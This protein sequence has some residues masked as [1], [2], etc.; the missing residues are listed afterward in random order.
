MRRFLIICALL[1]TASASRANEK[2]DIGR[3]WKFFTHEAAR[4]DVAPTVNL[5]H[6]WNADALAGYADYFRGMGNYLKTI[7][8]PASWSG[9]KIYL[10]FQGA[11]MF[12]DVFVNGA[13]AGEHRGGY[14]PFTIDITRFV[15]PG[16]EN[17][18]LVGVSNAVRYDMLP[19]AG[20]NNFYGG[21]IRGAEVIAVPMGGISPNS[22][23]HI[24]Q[25]SVTQDKVEGE[26]LVDIVAERDRNLTVQVAFMSNAMDTVARFAARVKTGTDGTATAKIPFTIVNPTLWNGTISPYL[27][28]VGV[29][30]MDGSYL[31]DS[32]L[33]ET[34][35]RTIAY[36]SAGGLIVN[37]MPYKVNGVKVHQDRPIVGPAI[38]E[39]DAEEDVAM[40]MD[41]GANA[42][43]VVGAPH[44]PY[45]YT[46]CDR[47]GILV[48]SDMPL[49]GGTTVTDK[50]FVNSKP[51]ADAGKAQVMEIMKWQHNHPSVAMWG[52]FSDL[53][54]RGDNP[55]PYVKELNSM[56]KKED[57]SRLT[58]ASSNQDGDIN[59][60][61]DLI[62]WNQ[63]LGWKEGSPEDISVWLTQL[64]NNWRNTPSGISYA[65]GGSATQQED[66]PKQP[67]Y[68]SNWHPEDWQTHLHEVYS[69]A[70]DNT[71]MWGTFVDLFEY[72]SAEYTG[73]AGNG[74]NDTGLVTFDRRTK[75][76]AFYLYKANWNH[77]DPFIHIAGRRNRATKSLRQDIKAFTN[78]S[79]AE[80]FV[81]GLSMGAK[82]PE[83]G[84]VV[85]KDVDLKPGNN[86]IEIR[87]GDVSD[88]INR[89]GI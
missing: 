68:D 40:I 5:P 86:V 61:T 80:L 47:N 77:V 74:I 42:V 73:G 3:D 83:M 41:M 50:G 85:W 7:D 63:H 14:V 70:L 82:N 78:R 23:V 59:F 67:V 4:S 60:I 30:V 81:N 28:T 8:I 22:G 48:W 62:V 6:T 89:T 56:I 37:G 29:T 55:I 71:W 33:I 84:V 58:I 9:K 34:G 31:V 66:K 49:M 13:Y 19:T 18:I 79:E 27:Y 64:T 51:F 17:F 32:E 21:L 35:F 69:K 87:G 25:K 1:C 38:T 45:F 11:N 46:L 26:A 88:T 54:V 2:I 24:V 53:S 16:K 36:D 39:A 76:D 65:A 10:K 12:T 44:H 52:V 75:K 72:G 20:D 43:R 15:K 57:P